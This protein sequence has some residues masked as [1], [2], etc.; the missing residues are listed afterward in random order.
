MG[1]LELEQVSAQFI[2]AAW[3]ATKTIFNYLLEVGEQCLD[4]VFEVRRSHDRS[5]YEQS[6]KVCI[7]AVFTE[8]AEL[9]VSIAKTKSITTPSHYYVLNYPQAWIVTAAAAAAVEAP[10]RPRSLL[11]CPSS[12]HTA[13]TGPPSSSC[14]QP[15]RYPSCS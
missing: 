14:L 3:E 9:E 1:S 4:S 6:F 8:F 12:A 2:Y 7:A 11:R 15:S 5:P 13:H 10:S